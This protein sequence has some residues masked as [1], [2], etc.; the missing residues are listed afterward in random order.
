MV[1]GV[2]VTRKPR[3]HTQLLPTSLLTLPP[4]PC[5]RPTR[6]QGPGAAVM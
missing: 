6:P 4:L 5:W 1:E 2:V 3:P